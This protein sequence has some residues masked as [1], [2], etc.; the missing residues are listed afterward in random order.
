VLRATAPG[1]YYLDEPTWHAIRSTRRR[2]VFVL[3]AVIGL[4]ALYFVT[5]AGG[6]LF[7]PAR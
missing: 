1:R 7:S 3:L 6:H 5:V 4:A 2:L